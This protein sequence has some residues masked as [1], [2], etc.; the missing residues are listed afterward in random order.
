MPGARRLARLPAEPSAEARRRL[1]IMQW[2]VGHGGKVRLTARHFGYSPDTISRW[3]K[4]YGAEGV[5]GLEP[6]SRRPHRP[7]QPQTS[8]EVVERI[9]QLREHYPR[10]GREK[11]RV[12]LEGEGMGISAKSIDRVICRLKDRGVLREAIQPRKTALC[13][14]ERL[15]RPRDLVVDR[16]GALVQLDTK[17]VR[18]HSGKV[19]FQFAA[20]D[21]FTRKRVVALSP[22]LASQEGAS[23]L[24]KVIEEFPFPIAAIQSDGGSEFLGAFGQ[25]V[26]EVELIHYFNRPNYPQGNGRVERSFRTDE[27]E[28]YQVQE[29]P[30]DLGG[31]LAALL[32]WN[33]VYEQVRPHQALGYKTPEQFYQDW[34]KDHPDRKEVLSDMS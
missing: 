3:L 24:R 9:L 31:Q 15:R 26:R 23:F 22:R 32:A 4:G 8:L 16:P 29:L 30:A 21:C 1:G 27:E 17:Q 7:R 13:R 10:W 14:Q 20:V 19:A 33:K 5:K 34:L 11:L 18:H 6:G 12:L 25:A 28:F 2:C